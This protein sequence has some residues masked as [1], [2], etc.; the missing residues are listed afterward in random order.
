MGH[1][2]IVWVCDL[3]D[4]VTISDSREHHKMDGC[5]CGENAVDLEQAYCRIVGRPGT[6]RF[7]AKL[8]E[9]KKWAYVRGSYEP[10]NK[11]HRPRVKGFIEKIKAFGGFI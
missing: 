8:R 1:M 2:K 6:M 7:I 10:T 4:W 3:C 11:K 5:Q 9:G